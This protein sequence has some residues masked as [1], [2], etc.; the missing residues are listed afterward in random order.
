MNSQF[1]AWLSGLIGVVIFSGSLPAT[2]I[3]VMDFNPWFL[4]GI[5]AV[6]AGIVAMVLL[7][8]LKAKRPSKR[9][10]GNLVYVAVGVVVGFPLFTALALQHISAAFSIVFI[11][12]LPL[13]TAIF[14]VLRSNERPQLTFWLFSLFGS[15]LVVLY[16]LL[17]ISLNTQSFFGILYM[18]CA[19]ILCG[20]GYAEGANLAKKIGGWQ[21]IC[22]ALV[23]SLPVMLIVTIYNYSS[24]ILDKLT[25]SGL[26]AVLYISIFSMLI[27]FFFWY[28]GL[29]KGGIASV[30]QLQLLQPFM[31]LALAAVIL[32]EPISANMLIITAGVICCVASAKK[33]A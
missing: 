22:W 25:L 18:L 21:V 19:I 5:R 15:G 14:A 27:G 29:S 11:G 17:D 13:C 32:Y 31:G 20:F 10:C 26:V 7:K 33:F 30:G 28:Y 23:I 3:A 4:T 12:L 8:I 16:I 9:D 1:F 24:E 2:R 6:I